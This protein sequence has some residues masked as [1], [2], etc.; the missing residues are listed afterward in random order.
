[1][2]KNFAV[3]REQMSPASQACSEAKAQATLA[4]MPLNEL[5]QARGMSQKMLA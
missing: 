1:M 5:R 3:L 2:A 4:E